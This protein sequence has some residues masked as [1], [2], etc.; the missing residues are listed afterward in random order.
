[1]NSSTIPGHV[2]TVATDD[3]DGDLVLVG[4]A[5]NH[6]GITS[7]ASRIGKSSIMPGKNVNISTCTVGFLK[8][9]V[10]IL[11]I[12]VLTIIDMSFWSETFSDKT[13]AICPVESI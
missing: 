9:K 10:N 5:L 4:T 2:L 6:D 11:Y 1:L 7:S 8:K 3:P 13:H 12:P